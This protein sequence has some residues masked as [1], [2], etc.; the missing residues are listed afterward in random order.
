MYKVRAWRGGQGVW[1]AAAAPDA[2]VR[3]TPLQAKRVCA[4]PLALA[5]QEAL[6]GSR[7]AAAGQAAAPCRRRPRSGLLTMSQARSLIPL[8]AAEA[9]VRC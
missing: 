9:P 4:V 1:V 6:L 7:R 5:L 3:L 2:S 8:D